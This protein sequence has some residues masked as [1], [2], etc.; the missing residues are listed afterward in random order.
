MNFKKHDKVR[1]KQTFFEKL[2]AVSTWYLYTGDW[3]W[4]PPRKGHVL[5]WRDEMQA[6][7]IIDLKGYRTWYVVE[8]R[9]ELI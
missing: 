8:E 3:I 2:H 1:I 6:W 4:G 9:L 5:Y 7:E